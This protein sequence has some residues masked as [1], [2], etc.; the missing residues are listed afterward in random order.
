MYGI[1]DGR[2]IHNRLESGLLARKH[3]EEAGDVA[4]S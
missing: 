1:V 4:V 2:R 3:A